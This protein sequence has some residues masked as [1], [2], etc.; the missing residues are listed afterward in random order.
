MS[1]KIVRLVHSNSVQEEAAGWIARID[2]EG[3]RPELVAQ[4]EAWQAQSPRHAQAARELAVLWT[5][6]DT[7][8]ESATAPARP[9]RL[10]RRQ[11]LAAG[12]AMA[13]TLAL[14][15]GLWM[16]QRPAAPTLYEAPVGTHRLI[17]LADGSK[18][19]LNT[20]GQVEVRYSGQA[21]DIRL[22]KGEAYFEVAPDAARPFSVYAQS[23]VVRALGTAFAVRL[24]GGE[25]EVTLT[26]GMIELAKLE[27]PASLD[28]AGA[29]PRR[30]L[31]TLSA[32]MGTES[33]TIAADGGFSLE[34]GTEEADR[35][36][37][38]RRGILVFAGE[39][40]PEVVA[41]VS[42]YT[43]MD[44]EIADPALNELRVAGNFKAGEVE[45]MLEA[46]QTGF[47]VRVERAGDKRVRLSAGS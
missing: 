4:F 13:A 32:A 16:T 24:D 8:A 10:A 31:A 28:Q 11:V 39:T 23:G 12:A 40:L 20:G 5:D 17:A 19:D 29:A 2:R 15:A 25:V 22:L 35:K 30:R 46:L 26:K 18:I 1:D 38:W 33:A 41:D 27:A 42:R 14:A 6:L 9:A 3:A 37:A 34:A 43:D 7:L 36:L 21:R 45:A 44:I 47:G